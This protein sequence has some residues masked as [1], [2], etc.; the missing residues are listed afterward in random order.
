[1]SFPISVDFKGKD[2]ISSRL[3]FSFREHM[4]VIVLFSI[5]LSL[6]CTSPQFTH[7]FHTPFQET[8]VLLHFLQAFIMLPLHFLLRQNYLVEVF[9]TDPISHIEISF[10]RRGMRRYRHLHQEEN[11]LLRRSS[12]SFVSVAIKI[13]I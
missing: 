4:Q 8:L 11:F 6:S 12:R 10:T 13:F 7:C 1:M 3:L 5:T 2:T 9:H